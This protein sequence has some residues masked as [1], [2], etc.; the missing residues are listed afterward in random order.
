[1]NL[2]TTIT[3]TTQLPRPTV[4]IFSPDDVTADGLV[5]AKVELTPDAPLLVRALTLVTTAL[6]ELNAVSTEL[7]FVASIVHVATLHGPEH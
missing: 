4:L 5:S 6:L 2:A 1:M 7:V 3:A